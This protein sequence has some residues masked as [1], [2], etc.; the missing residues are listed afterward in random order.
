M[1]FLVLCSTY[2]MSYS[3][4]PKCANFCIQIFFFMLA[5]TNIQDSKFEYLPHP[6]KFSDLA[7]SANHVFDLLVRFVLSFPHEAVFFLLFFLQPYLILFFYKINQHFN[8]IVV[9]Y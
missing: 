3:F 7:P 5:I 6:P 8:Y 4:E 2:I 1:Y 9:S